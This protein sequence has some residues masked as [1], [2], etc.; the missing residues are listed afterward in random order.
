MK[1]MCECT[2]PF[3]MEHF[4][5]DRRNIEYYFIKVKTYKVV[6]VKKGYGS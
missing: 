1:G 3:C 4:L 6:N 2:F 5:E